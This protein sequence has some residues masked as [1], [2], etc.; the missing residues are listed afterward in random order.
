MRTRR[1]S[2]GRAATVATLLLLGTLS[3]QRA[4]AETPA[5]Q[6]ETASSVI[7]EWAERVSTTV[8]PEELLGPVRPIM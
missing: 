5:P 2:K 6:P 8:N 7:T 4:E 3:G 1:V